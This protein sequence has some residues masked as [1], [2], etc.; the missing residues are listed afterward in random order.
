MN[1]MTAKEFLEVLKH[2]GIHINRYG[3][4]YILVFIE[5]VFWD[6]EKEYSEKYPCTAKEKAQKAKYIHNILKEHGYY[7]D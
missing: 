5:R 4:E 6:E 3:Y 1:K 2:V 7:K